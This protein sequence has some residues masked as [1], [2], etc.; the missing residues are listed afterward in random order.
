MFYYCSNLTSLDLS[1]FN[2]S[3]VTNMTNMFYECR[4]LTS[5]D[6]SL[7]NTSKITIMSSMF[8]YCNGLT[9]L[10]LSS[11]DTSNVNAWS[12]T[13]D[14]ASLEQIKGTISLKSYS[15]STMNYYSI[16][17]FSNIPLYEVTIK[18]IGYHSNAKQFNSQKVI[19]WGVEN[20]KYPNAR[21]SLIDSLITYS[22]DRATAGYATCTITLSANSKSALTNDEI[23]QITAKGF[24]IA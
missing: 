20:D 14:C 2:T 7:F 10:D 24:T 5:L 6:L 17:G 9:S 12:A 11:F 13:F 4:N 22:F 15:A 1:S 23:A 21:Q 8:G 18:D 19:Y 16:F 3:N